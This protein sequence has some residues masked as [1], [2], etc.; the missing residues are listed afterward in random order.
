MSEMI[1]KLVNYDEEILMVKNTEK[2]Q[3]ASL[4]LFAEKLGYHRNDYHQNYQYH[5][6]FKAVASVVKLE[7]M[8]RWHNNNFCRTYGNP[9]YM[10]CRPSYY[11]ETKYFKLCD[12]A[13]AVQ[14]KLVTK[15][16]LQYSKKS[17]KIIVVD[18]VIELA[19]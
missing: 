7:T 16:K 2:L 13:E 19:Y 9:F 3:L 4:D 11:P 8:Q 15:T 12:M 10:G 14:S 5:G 17:K 6:P 18:H 1:R